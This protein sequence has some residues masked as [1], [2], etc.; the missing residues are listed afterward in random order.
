MDTVHMLLLRSNDLGFGTGQNK[1][2]DGTRLNKS[3]C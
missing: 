3:F 2:A 1:L